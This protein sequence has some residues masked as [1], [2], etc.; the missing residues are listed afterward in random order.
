M[1]LPIIVKHTLRFLRFSSLI[2]SIAST[3]PF[4]AINLPQKRILSSFLYSEFINLL[5]NRAIILCDAP[6]QVVSSQIISRAEKTG[7]IVPGHKNKTFDELTTNREKALVYKRNF[8]KFLENNKVPILYL[9][10]TDD[11]TRNAAKAREFI[12]MQQ[13]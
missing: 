8:V 2:I 9:N 7:K 1:P 10:T 4:K 12:N 13:H 5:K 6:A 11:P 3:E